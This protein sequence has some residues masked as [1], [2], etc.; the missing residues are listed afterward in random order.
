M[1][2]SMYE[3][4]GGDRFFTDL[5]AE[6]YR[7]VA[8]D[9]LL[10]PMY[11]DEDLGPAERRLRLFLEQYWGGPTTYSDE[12]GHPRLRQR[13][14]PFVIGPEERDRWLSHMYAA[15][16]AQHLSEE[17]EAQLWSYLVSAAFAMVNSMPDVRE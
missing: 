6:F 7:R 17:D 5:V 9:D 3:Q 16:E 8:A 10:R 15:L 12:R 1:T 13:H 11:P 4:F 2:V 14:M